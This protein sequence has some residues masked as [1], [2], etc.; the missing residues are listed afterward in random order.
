[1]PTGTWPST[2]Q[3]G[4]N[5]GQPHPASGLDKQKYKASGEL[6]KARASRALDPDRFKDS[7]AEHTLYGEGETVYS[8]KKVA[9]VVGD[10]EP[11]QK[12]R[13]MTLKDAIGLGFIA[14]TLK[15]YANKEF[16]TDDYHAI[17]IGENSDNEN[18][19]RWSGRTDLG[20]IA[21]AV[22]Q[23]RAFGTD[24]DKKITV[25][26]LANP[27]IKL[28]NQNLWSTHLQQAKATPE[29]ETATFK[30]S[31]YNDRGLHGEFSQSAYFLFRDKHRTN[32]ED[33]YGTYHYGKLKTKFEYK[34]RCHFY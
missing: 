3:K 10:T 19:F 25:E 33:R 26:P 23:A 30:M 32:N 16:Y 4:K 22:L 17:S 9:S 2:I 31:R 12:Y 18:R 5:K 21:P 29:G 34:Y 14:D 28:E 20:T 7:T 8:G 11:A 27:P 24:M 15:F 6:R 13:I 1:M